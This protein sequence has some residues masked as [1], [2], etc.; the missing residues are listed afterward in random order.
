[1]AIVRPEMRALSSLLLTALIVGCGSGSPEPPVPNEPT[2]PNTSAWEILQ[3]KL[4]NAGSDASITLDR[5]ATYVLDSGLDLRDYSGVRINGNGATIR[6]VSSDKIQ[7]T[8]AADYAG[9]VD[10]VLESVPDNYRV[11]DRLAIANGQTIDDVTKNPRKITAIS[12]T[13]VTIEHPFN[14]HWAT[15]STVFKTFY[16]IRGLSS[17]V[18]GNPGTIIE[19]LTFDGNARENDI[20]FGWV[21]NGTIGLHGGKTSEIRFNRFVDIPNETIV[22]HGVSVHGN[23]FDGLNGS[24]FHTSVHDNTLDLNGLASFVNNEVFN[25]NRVPKGANGHSEGA[26]TFS[27]GAGNLTVANNYFQSS[28]GNYGVLGKFSGSAQHTDENLTVTDNIAVNFEYIIR[29]SSPPAT[30][31]RNILITRN[32][33]SN[34]GVNDFTHLA[35]NPTVRLGCNTLLDGT[36]ML[37]DPANSRCE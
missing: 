18:G 15:G 19:N 1:M 9:G 14:D 37:I 12:G 16:L 26:I 35:T 13:T 8:L 7:T 6:R 3:G 27:W 24:S 32:S 34:A 17:T 36:Q 20:N 2:S 21:I 4:D 22:G 11:G 25:V 29:I 30:P 28:S 33:F 10:L 5:A 23:V 31:T